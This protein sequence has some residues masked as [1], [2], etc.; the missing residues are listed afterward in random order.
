[1]ARGQVALNGQTLAEGDSAAVGQESE[2]RLEAPQ[3]AE[4]LLFDLA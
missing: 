2:I 4:V 3:A 1:M